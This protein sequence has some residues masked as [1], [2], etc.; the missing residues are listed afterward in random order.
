M[1]LLLQTQEFDVQVAVLERVD[2][3]HVE[4]QL[5]ETPGG[6]KIQRKA[7]VSGQVSSRLVRSLTFLVPTATA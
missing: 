6:M 2:D 4:E 1:T 3:P 7:G 5:P